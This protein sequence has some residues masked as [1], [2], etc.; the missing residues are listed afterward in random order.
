MAAAEI[1]AAKEIAAALTAARQE[2]EEYR[3]NHEKE[4]HSILDSLK[5]ELATAREETIAERE[6]GQQE[7]ERAA[8]K[9]AA[10]EKEAESDTLSALAEARKESEDEYRSMIA[11]AVD[12]AVTEE[13]TKLEQES[14]KAL[15]NLTDKIAKM[16]IDFEST[17][18]EQTLDNQNAIESALIKAKAEAEMKHAAALE[19]FT[20]KS[21]QDKARAVEAVQERARSEVQAFERQIENE[22]SLRQAQS[23]SLKE[24]HALEVERIVGRA[25]KDAAMA[26]ERLQ[27]QIEKERADH[28]RAK[29]SSQH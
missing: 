18:S 29:R 7:T 6:R 20:E 22:N 3:E 26:S 12:A 10:L 2:A 23:K 17:I 21:S 25:R 9:V 14:S 4:L 8:A 28:Q 15:S 16:E 1:R 5:S 24:E 11:S 13:R 19:E 27:A